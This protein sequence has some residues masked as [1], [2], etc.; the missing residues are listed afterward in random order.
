MV[1]G[2]DGQLFEVAEY[3]RGGRAKKMKTAAPMTANSIPMVTGLA[4]PG[5]LV[6]GEPILII[7]ILFNCRL[8]RCL[9]LSSSFEGYISIYSDLSLGAWSSGSESR[10]KWFGI[11]YA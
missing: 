8:Y 7:V 6:R 10:M 4:L 11:V 2:T 1:P 3:C 5:F 9:F